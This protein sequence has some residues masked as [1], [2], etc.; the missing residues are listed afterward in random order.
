M[1][2]IERRKPRIPRMQSP[3]C[4]P[5]LP[6]LCSPPPFPATSLYRWPL[7]SPS[8]RPIRARRS[9]PTCSSIGLAALTL[10]QPL[11]VEG[12][13][14]YSTFKMHADFIHG[15]VNM[16]PGSTG[17]EIDT[18]SSGRPAWSRWSGC[19]VGMD[20]DGVGRSGVGC[21]GRD[22]ARG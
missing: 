16:P 8:S 5:H 2:S 1:K 19:R 21:W 9:S 15:S 22:A 10:A 12:M 3:H 18:G 7:P 17:L 20:L 6:C 4:T 13:R 11:L 14:Q